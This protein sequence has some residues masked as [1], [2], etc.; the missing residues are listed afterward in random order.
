MCRY[1]SW[2]ELSARAGS[3]INNG[4]THYVQYSVS[5]GMVAV[6]RRADVENDDV[7]YGHDGN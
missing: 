1:G 7:T 4:S 2:F 6:M 3:L 5:Q